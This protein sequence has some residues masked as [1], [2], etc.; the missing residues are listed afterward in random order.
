LCSSNTILTGNNFFGNT[1]SDH[2]WHIQV[3]GSNTP[4]V[5]LFNN[6]FGS[7]TN[8]NEPGNAFHTDGVFANSGVPILIYAFNN[9]F[10]PGAYGTTQFYCTFATGTPGS[11]CSA[12][13]FNNI[14]DYAGYPGRSSLNMSQDPTYPMGPL[15]A[16][17][18]TFFNSGVAINGGVSVYSENNLISEVGNNYFYAGG[19]RSLP[20]ALSMSDY[21]DFYGG[22]GLSFADNF[23]GG[24]DWWDWPTAGGGYSAWTSTGF[25][26]HSVSGDPKLD[27]TYH[28]QVGSAAIG[29]GINLSSLCSSVPP[30]C[31]DR[32][33][34][35]RPSAGAWDIGAYQSFGGPAPPT[36][37]QAVPH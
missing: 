2:S 18:N 19:S 4:I 15:Y 10:Q 7:V 32:A 3:A 11:G 23:G 24:N 5:N 1:L 29:K 30:L 37:L 36:G 26:T 14:F 22:R 21:N 16:Y 20:T 12:W 8:W 9:Y 28:L 6:T 17:N 27:G 25:D 33:G 31:Y 34:A 35:A 13:V